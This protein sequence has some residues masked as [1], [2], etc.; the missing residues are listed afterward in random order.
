MFA[1]ARNKVARTWTVL[2]VVVFLTC[3]FAP[4]V[5]WGGPGQEVGEQVMLIQMITVTLLSAVHYYASRAL[6]PVV[7][8]DPARGSGILAGRTVF[9]WRNV[10][11]D[12]LAS[13]RYSEVWTRETYRPSPCYLDLRD[14]HGNRLVVPVSDRATLRIIRPAV[15][16][17][18]TRMQLSHHAAV[19][20]GMDPHRARTGPACHDARP[21]LVLASVM[22][23]GVIV[24][25]VFDT[26][27]AI[28]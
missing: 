24:F 20:L 23:L 7:G 15:S 27:I 22:V 26:L 6:K 11:L 25:T 12:A 2:T 8:R 10:D 18:R 17:D 5:I 16:R 4:P 19:E 21:T 1:L 28:L 13:V 3:V 9:G 14:R